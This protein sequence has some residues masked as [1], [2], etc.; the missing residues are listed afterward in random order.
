MTGK[1]A[2]KPPAAANNDIVMESGIDVVVKE[3]GDTEGLVMSPA[4][5]KGRLGDQ[6]G[7]ISFEY[8]LVDVK[9]FELPPLVAITVGG[10]VI[11]PKLTCRLS[12]ATA[13]E[14]DVPPA[15]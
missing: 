6:I 12:A 11:P 7:L 13:S 5:I 3:A 2:P 8:E 4:R 1:T 10:T 14:T 15:R 9:V